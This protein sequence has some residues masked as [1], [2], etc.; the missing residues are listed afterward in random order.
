MDESVVFATPWFELIARTPPGWTAPHYSVRGPDYVTV[1]A[2][3][4]DG[5]LL[6]VRQYRPAVDMTTL[7]LV[8]G[9][10]DPGQTAEEGARCEL[11]EETGYQTGHLELLGE[12]APD[13]GRLTNRLWVF[14]AEALTPAAEWRPEA[15]VE[16][17]LYRG[18]LRDLLGDRAFCHAL[19]H[20]ALLLAF[21]AGRVKLSD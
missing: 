4:P 16:R 3:T 1:I 17:I 8:S 11:L 13:V 21:A 18:S 9:H 6:L 19:N 20:A 10:V 2:R 12:L 15:D 14:F 7:E 5:A